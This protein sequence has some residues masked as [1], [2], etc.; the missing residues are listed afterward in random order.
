M[1]KASVL[2]NTSAGVK[3][4][5]LPFASSLARFARRINPAIP[6]EDTEEGL[7]SREKKAILNELDETLMNL[8]CARHNFEQATSPEIIEAC[9][10][11]IK[12]AESRYNFLLAKAKRLGINHTYHEVRQRSR[13]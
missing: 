3:G 6:S 4:F 12:S 5:K 1:D 10:Y 9:I 7:F 8:R 11:E 2:K 13:R